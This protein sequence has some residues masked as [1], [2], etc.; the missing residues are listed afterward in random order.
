MLKGADLLQA[1]LELALELVAAIANDQSGR[2]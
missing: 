1:A 2:A